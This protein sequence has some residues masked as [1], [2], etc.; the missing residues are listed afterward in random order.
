MLITLLSVPILASIAIAFIDTNSGKEISRVKQTALGAS[1]VNF[2]VSII[3]WTSFNS[4]MPEGTYQFTQ[5]FLEEQVSFCHLH[6]GVDGISLYF[7]LLTT[8][9]TPIC[10]LSN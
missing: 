4:N 1:L 10:I 8:L 6:I 5:E 7:V 2:V 9:I 3:L